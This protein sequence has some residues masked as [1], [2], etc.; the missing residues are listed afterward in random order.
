MHEMMRKPT[1][2][3][4]LRQKHRLWWQ[5]Q[6]VDLESI[7]ASVIVNDSMDQ[8]AYRDDCAKLALAAL[9][10][11]RGGQVPSLGCLVST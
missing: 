1:M 8:N 6:G 4:K 10:H 9:A 2:R 11:C 7:C 5:M 3:S